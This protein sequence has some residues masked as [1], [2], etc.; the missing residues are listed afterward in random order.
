MDLCALLK[1]EEEALALASLLQEQVEVQV[2]RTHAGL[3]V[4]TFSVDAKVKG[5]V[6]CNEKKVEERPDISALSRL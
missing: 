3:F 5:Q 6:A 1:L 4:A 2:G